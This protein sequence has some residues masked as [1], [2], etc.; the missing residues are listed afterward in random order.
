MAIREI[1]CRIMISI[2]IDC[3]E[4]F[5]I[6]LNSSFSLLSSQYVMFQK[7]AQ[8]VMN[9]YLVSAFLPQN[10]LYMLTLPWMN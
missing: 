6:I 7:D 9:L 2:V 3:I 4:H 10:N 1:K 5:Q 8:G